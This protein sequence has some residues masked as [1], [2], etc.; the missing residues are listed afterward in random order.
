[1]VRLVARMEK[2]RGAYRGL[3]VK[4]EG[5]RPLGMPGPRWEDNIKII[6]K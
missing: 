2:G 4:P 5:K 6:L 3:D 1:M